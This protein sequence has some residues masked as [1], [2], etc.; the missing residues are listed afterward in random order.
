MSQAS[1]RRAVRYGLPTAM[2]AAIALSGAAPAAA[3][4]PT[5]KVT[6]LEKACTVVGTHGNDRLIGTHGYDV[7]CG[8]GGDDVIEAG[9]GDDVIDGGD[10]NDTIVGDSGNDTVGAGAGNDS[11]TGGAGDDVLNGSDGDDRLDGGVGADN[12]E[13]G[14]GVNTCPADTAD[15]SAPNSCSDVAA[16]VVD[17]GSVRYV[18]ETVLDNSAARTVRLQ[19]R[20]TDDRAGIR[21]GLVYAGAGGTSVQLQ[22]PR[23]ISGT[24]NDGVWEFTGTVPAYA[25][26]GTWNISQIFVSDRVGRNVNL[27]QLPTTMPTF[28]VNGA[29]DLTAPVVDLP[30]ARYVGETVLDNSAART[31]R[32]QVRLTD[33]RAGINSGLVYASAGGTSVQLQ[34]PRLISGTINDGVWEFTGTVPAYAPAGTWKITQIFVSDRVGRN[35]NLMQLPTTMPTFEVRCPA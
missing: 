9:D 21:S 8:L 31:V 5:T 2:A 3:A 24:I 14:T 13:G 17:L 16:P 30:S 1:Y 26:A 7:I 15:V 25:P 29:A 23:L 34:S 33:D 10:G 4:G 19:V 22:S 32:L 28:T 18:G 6:G 27:M 35:V 12:V 11:V 20:L